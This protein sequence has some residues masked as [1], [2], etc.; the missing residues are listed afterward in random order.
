MFWYKV[1]GLHALSDL[2]GENSTST[3]KAKLLLNKALQKLSDAYKKAY[4]GKVLFTVVAT[5]SAHT[6]RVRAADGDEPA[7]DLVLY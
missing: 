5:D 7:Q 6:R 3:K 1:S 2:H 4:D